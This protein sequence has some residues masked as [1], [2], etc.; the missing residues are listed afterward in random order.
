MD[1]QKVFFFLYDIYFVNFANHSFVFS[2]E[3]NIDFFGNL[4]PFSTN[5]SS[6]SVI[7]DRAF[8]KFGAIALVANITTSVFDNAFGVANM[9]TPGIRWYF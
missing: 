6:I 3:F 7:I 8:S 2:Q 1:L 4:T 5:F 9:T